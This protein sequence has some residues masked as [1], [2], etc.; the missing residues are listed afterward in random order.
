MS[1]H[2]CFCAPLNI[3]STGYNVPRDSHDGDGRN[4]LGAM[5][6]C[7]WMEMDGD[8]YWHLSSSDGKKG[9]ISIK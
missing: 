6:N 5:W 7:N 3:I 9:Q 2:F 1:L 4:R 8:E